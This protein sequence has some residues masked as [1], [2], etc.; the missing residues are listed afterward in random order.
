MTQRF[1]LRFLL[2]LAGAQAMANEGRGE[3][4]GSK[5]QHRY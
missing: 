1:S 3:V 4:K 5:K 2:L